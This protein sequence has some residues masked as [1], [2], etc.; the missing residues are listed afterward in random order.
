MTL[1]PNAKNSPFFS[2]I[3]DIQKYIPFN[4]ALSVKN[5]IQEV[6][7]QLNLDGSVANAVEVLR[8]GMQKYQSEYINEK[9][10]MTI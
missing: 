7:L 8:Q 10:I 3:E 5:Y 9:K 1:K 6:K 4:L 2:Q